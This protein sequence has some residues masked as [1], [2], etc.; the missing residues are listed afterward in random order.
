MVNE[1]DTIP[2]GVYGCNGEMTS[3]RKEWEDTEG[4]IRKIVWT[5][6]KCGSVVN[7]GITTEPKF[8]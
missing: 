4:M 1:K 5:C 3:D 8:L 6:R 2:C 7:A